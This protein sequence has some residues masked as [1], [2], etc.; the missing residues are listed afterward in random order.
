MGF[1]TERAKWLGWCGVAIGL[2]LWVLV[3]SGLA[4]VAAP[5]PAGHGA[6]THGEHGAVQAGLSPTGLTPEEELAYSLFMHRSS[7]IALVILGVLVMADRLTRRRYG[8]IQIGIGLLWLAFGAHLFIRS[9]LEGWPVGPAGFVESFSMATAGEWMQHK[10]LSLIPLTL[11]VW[12]LTSR[13]VLPSASWNYALGAVLSV[14]VAGLLIHQHL[15]HR[16][17]DLVNLQHRLM[18]LTALVIAAGSVAEG[19]G[20]FRWTHKPLLV[21]CG[22]LVLGLQLVFYIE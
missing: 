17:M 3:S 12:T 21:P 10:A 20:R 15:D 7:G 9:D 14:G 6:V 5:D 4:D 2:G 19:L 11:G 18:A 13:S 16:T 22:F 8:S 1:G